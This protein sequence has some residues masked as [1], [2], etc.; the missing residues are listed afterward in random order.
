LVQ[1]GNEQQ[2]FENLSSGI[3][4][5]KV[6]DIPPLE[7]EANI[8][9]QSKQGSGILS[10]ITYGIAKTKQKSVLSQPKAR[11]RIKDTLPVFYFVFDKTNK[12]SLSES[13]NSWFSTAKS[14]NEFVLVKLL[15]SASKKSREVETGS[16]NSYEGLSVGID[17]KHKVD[18][19]YE[20]LTNNI[21]KISFRRPLPIGEYC[22]VYAGS[23]INSST[24]A[25]YKVFDFGID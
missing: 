7:I 1:A 4:Y 22:F 11:H 8:F 15:L 18:F 3:Y 20:K 13:Q 5:Q 10:A 19:E 6:K 14:P 2:V 9:S 16:Y 25:T 23:N 21:Y 24:S 17:E 12:G